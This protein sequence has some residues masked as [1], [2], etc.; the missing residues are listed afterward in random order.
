VNVREPSDSVPTE[1]EGD[2]SDAG[3]HRIRR[4]RFHERVS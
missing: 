1:T 2:R 4:C 3:R